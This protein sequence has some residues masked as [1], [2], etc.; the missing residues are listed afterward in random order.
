M[1]L[2]QALRNYI[3]SFRHLFAPVIVLKGHGIFNYITNYSYKLVV[4]LK[5]V[6]MY[7][8]AQMLRRT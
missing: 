7:S 1:N 5:C 3:S 8:I 6:T 2:S 4:I